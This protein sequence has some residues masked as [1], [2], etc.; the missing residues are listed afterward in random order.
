MADSSRAPRSST[1]HDRVGRRFLAEF[2]SRAVMVYS[3]PPAVV[4]GV[5]PIV[6][7][8]VTVGTVVWTVRYAARVRQELPTP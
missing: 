4:L 1:R 7:G 5:A 3:F 8:F 6:T 2:I